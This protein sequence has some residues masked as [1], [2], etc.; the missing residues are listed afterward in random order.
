MEEASMIDKE[1]RKGLFWMKFESRKVNGQTVHPNLSF[2][3]FVEGIGFVQFSL[4]GCI[5]V[6]LSRECIFADVYRLWPCFD[7]SL[8]QISDLNLQMNFYS[9]K[10][11]MIRNIEFI[12]FVSTNDQKKCESSVPENNIVSSVC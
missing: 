12:C 7:P 2:C 4:F 3:Q 6:I 10:E 8:N 5:D 1:I 9:E 11:V